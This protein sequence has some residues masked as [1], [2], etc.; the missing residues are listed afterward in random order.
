MAH[1]RRPAPRS[2]I[3]SSWAL[4]TVSDREDLQGAMQADARGAPAHAEPLPDVARAEP[5]DRD[6]LDDAALAL[7]QAGQH[8][9]GVG[10]RF[11][12]RRLRR[13][14]RLDVVADI[15]VLTKAAP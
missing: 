7:G 4:P 14:Q 10:R 1:G 9:P 15:D 3:R 11:R 8:L 6:R 2:G 13:R 12:L 5:L